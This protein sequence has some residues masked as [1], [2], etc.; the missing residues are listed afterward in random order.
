MGIELGPKFI[1]G[2]AGYGVGRDHKKALDV[3]NPAV[4]Q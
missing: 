3:Q 4:S 2:A 1:D